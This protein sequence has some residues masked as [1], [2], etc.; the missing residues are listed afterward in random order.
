MCYFPFLYLE[1]VHFNQRGWQVFKV[2]VK[3]ANLIR[4]GGLL[5]ALISLVTRL[6]NAE[7][8][9]HLPFLGTYSVSIMG[10]AGHG[11]RGLP[12]ISVELAEAKRMWTEVATCKF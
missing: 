7:S 11:R 9:G 5:S 10:L 2:D 6:Q 3:I 1:Q 4:E 12:T 8:L